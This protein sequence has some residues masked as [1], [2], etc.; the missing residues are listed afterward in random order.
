MTGALCASYCSE[1]AY[2]G[3]EYSSE[4]WVCMIFSQFLLALIRNADD[5]IVRTV[6][7]EQ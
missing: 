2:F 7:K 5:Y 6:P 4:Y 3:L 1:F